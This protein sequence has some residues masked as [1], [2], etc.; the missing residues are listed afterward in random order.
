[1]TELESTHSSCNSRALPPAL[2]FEMELEAGQQVVATTD[3]VNFTQAV[4]F[5]QSCEIDR[6]CVE[7]H[8]WGPFERV[9][10]VPTSGTWFAI[11]QSELY[12]Q[13]SDV[14]WTVGIVEPEECDTLRDDDLDGDAG[15]RDADCLSDAYCGF[16]C[17]LPQAVPIVIS[18][19]D[20]SLE[21]A[22]LW[23]YSQVNDCVGEGGEDQMVAVY[24][25]VG[26]VITVTAPPDMPLPYV[27]VVHIDSGGCIPSENDNTCVYGHRRG[28]DYEV[29]SAGTH[30]VVLSTPGEGYS[31]SF[32]WVVDV[33]SN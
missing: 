21:S 11:I 19:D 31:G 18:G 26:D 29:E 27:N 3:D 28:A 9:F 7:H 30:F 6:V 1:M 10:D 33:S 8:G 5:S 4:S 12:V 22:N 25:A 24:A 2:V 16:Q 32:H 15:C 17:P 23:G 13:P 20:W 14:N